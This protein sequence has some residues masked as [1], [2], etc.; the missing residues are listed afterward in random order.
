MDRIKKT[1]SVSTVGL[2]LLDR[3]RDIPLTKK[4]VTI[5]ANFLQIIN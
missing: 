5:F 3:V 2:Y 1:V 4:P